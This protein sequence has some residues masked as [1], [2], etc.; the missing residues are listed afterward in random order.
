[1]WYGSYIT[2]LDLQTI[3]YTFVVRPTAQYGGDKTYVMSVARP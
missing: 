3:L 2:T 1:M